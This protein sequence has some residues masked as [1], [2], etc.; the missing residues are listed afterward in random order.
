MI[1]I[2]GN[3]IIPF[4]SFWFRPPTHSSLS[5]A[6]LFE[7]TSLRPSRALNL[8]SCVP[9]ANT[10]VQGRRQRQCCTSTDVLGLYYEK[11]TQTFFV[12][13]Q[14]SHLFYKVILDPNKKA[15]ELNKV[16]ERT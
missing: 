5:I 6:L 10:E 4:R 16:I 15:T 3:P 7:M 13:L 9:S 11:P 2:E 8:A 12:C 14:R 1:S